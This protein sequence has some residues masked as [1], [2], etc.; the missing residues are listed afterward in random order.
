[1]TVVQWEYQLVPV[2]P[3]AAK[4]AMMLDEQG[5]KGFEL[6]TIHEKLAIFK[7]PVENTRQSEG[8][9]MFGYSGSVRRSG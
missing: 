8:R 4:L 1:M 3:D 6:V 7:R 9:G 5:E 2:E